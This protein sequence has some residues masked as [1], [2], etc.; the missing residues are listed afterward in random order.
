MRMKRRMNRRNVCI[1]LTYLLIDHFHN[2]VINRSR[3]H[4]MTLL[5]AKVVYTPYEMD[6]ARATLTLAEAANEQELLDLLKTLT[7]ASLKMLYREIPVKSS[8]NKAQLIGQLVTYWERSF[9]G[10][11][12]DEDSAKNSKRMKTLPDINA[13]RHWNKDISNPIGFNLIQLYN[14]LVNSKCEETDSVCDDNSL[15]AYKSLKAYRYFSDGL[16]RN[17][18]T[19]C[20]LPKL[21][22][23]YSEVLV[24]EIL[25]RKVQKSVFSL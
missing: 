1:T 10:L 14:Y 5:L 20:I 19:N 16:V 22:T 9:A 2:D 18:W 3:S 17:V 24:P 13:I 8:G 15:K 23:F 21:V 11:E 7:V 6:R 12:S 4:H 25:T